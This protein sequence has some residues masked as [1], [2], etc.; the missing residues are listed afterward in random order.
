MPI[1]TIDDFTQYY[2]DL[3]D[4]SSPAVLLIS[5]LGGVGASWGPQIQRFA[6][7]FRVILPDQRGTGRS[8][9]AKGGYT[10]Q[11]LAAEMAALVEHL[12]CGPVHVV[13]ASTGGAIAQYMALDH[14]QTV[15]SLTLS[16]TF[17]RFDAFTHREFAVRRRMAE[18]WSRAD[19][20]AGYSLFLFSPRYTRE[21][22]EKVQA[23]IERGSS[24]PEQ[25]GDRVIGLARIDMIAAHDAFSRLG[26][27]DVPTVVVCGDH[28][29]CTPL[30]LSEELANAIPN[31]RLI[32]FSE[33]GEL[34]ELEQ[35]ERYFQVVSSFLHERREEV[36][37]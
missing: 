8:T 36:T 6:K 19:L 23:W 16:S 14:P 11:Q 21:H 9:H 2:E 10:T 35:E 18:L 1:V 24:H 20:F 37:Q 3:G 26:E 4:T 5:G 28:N 34:I 33:G 22:P 32:V 17:A 7:Q 12:G 25:P 15:R 30:A 29:F 27:I 31:A 13:G